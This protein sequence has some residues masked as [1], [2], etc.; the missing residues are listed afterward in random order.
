M[1]FSEGAWVTSVGALEP[2]LPTPPAGWPVVGKCTC[3]KPDPYSNGVMM[4][5]GYCPVHSP[6][7][8]C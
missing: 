8:T 7:A 3:P 6:S 4:W 5:G 2:A 1:Q